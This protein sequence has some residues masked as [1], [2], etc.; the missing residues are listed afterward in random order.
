MRLK[1]GIQSLFIIWLLAACQTATRLPYM[2]TTTNHEFILAPGQTIV[3][4]DADLTVAFHSILSD[5]RCPSNVD[6]V[7]SGPVDVSISA[8]KGDKPPA[9]IT[10]QVF[11]DYNGRAR[12]GLFGK[13]TDRAGVGDC[14]IRI[15]G[16]TPYPKDQSTPIEPSEYRVAFLITQY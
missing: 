5:E 1:A 8:Q 10:L 16:V 11:T 3:V 2:T 9:D 14:L 12:A 13:I 7:F 4:T 15:V 6:C